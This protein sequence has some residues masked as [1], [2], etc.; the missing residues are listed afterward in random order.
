MNEI[1]NDLMKT[2]NSLPKNP[3]AG[4]IVLIPAERITR[5]IETT[6]T[7]ESGEE[8]TTTKTETY[9][10]ALPAFRHIETEMRKSGVEYQLSEHAPQKDKN[11]KPCVFVMEKP[12]FDDFSYTPFGFKR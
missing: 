11:G 1:Y 2:I 9:L 12:R 5:E 10:A 6:E 7:N 3:F 8:I 4:M